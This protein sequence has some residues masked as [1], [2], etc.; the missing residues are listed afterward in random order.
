MDSSVAM[1]IMAIRD[2]KAVVN[3]VMCMMI[4]KMIYKITDISE[5]KICYPSTYMASV[6]HFRDKSRKTEERRGKSNKVIAEG[7]SENT[8]GKGRS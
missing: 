1:N 4:D 5:G 6:Q 7:E 3:A 2:Q 8:G